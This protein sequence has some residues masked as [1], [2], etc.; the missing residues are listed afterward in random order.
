[1]SELFEGKVAVV[2]GA[3]GA[4]GSVVTQEI[5]D[6][7]ASVVALYRSED[8]YQALWKSVG[9]DGIRLSGVV[10]DATREGDCISLVETAIRRHGKVYILLNIVGGYAGG[11]TVAETSKEEW[12][13]MMN[14][15]LR[16]V[17]YCSKAVLPHMIEQNYGKIVSVSA[18]SAEPSGRKAKSGAYA[19]SKAGVRV[20]TESIA[21]E[22]KD[23]EINVN[24]VMP[25]TI[26]TPANRADFPK[27]KFERWVPPEEIA[28]AILFLASDAS[29]PIRGAAV[30]VFGRS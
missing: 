6:R 27:A 30:P 2:T 21:E 23:Y 28:E 9:E 5:L 10:G 24:C 1:V 16:S 7:G 19:V 12:D 18:K 22:V 29:R 13:M 3:T 8:K 14:L 4:L 20:L 15:N 11:S 25:S 26:D 17:F